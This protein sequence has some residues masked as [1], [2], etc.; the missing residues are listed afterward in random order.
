M[1]NRLG[2]RTRGQGFPFF[3]VGGEG[4]LIQGRWRSMRLRV[5]SCGARRRA[6]AFSRGT[7]LGWLFIVATKLHFAIDAFALQ[8]FLERPEGLINIIVANHD[9]HKTE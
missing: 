8:L 2:D 9:L 4:A 3:L 6:A 5:P 7:F 1:G